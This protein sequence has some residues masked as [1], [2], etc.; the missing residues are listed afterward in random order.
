MYSVYIYT[1]QGSN[2]ALNWMSVGFSKDIFYSQS[3]TDFMYCH[4]RFLS[5]YIGII[6]LFTLIHIG[7]YY[8]YSQLSLYVLCTYI[9]FRMAYTYIMKKYSKV[10]MGIPKDRDM[11]WKK[12]N[13]FILI[14]NSAWSR[15]YQMGNNSSIRLDASFP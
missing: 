13:N 9:S 11:Y 10:L 14:I 15:K 1:Y 12:I 5:S 6:Y 2:Q 3:R 7:T 4:Q 8:F